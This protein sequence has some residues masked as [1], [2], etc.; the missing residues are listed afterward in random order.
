MRGGRVE[1]R[2]AEVDDL[3]VAGLGDEDVL[4]F[5]VYGG[6]V[7]RQYSLLKLLGAPSTCSLSCDLDDLPERSQQTSADNLPRCTIE[8]AWQY[9][10]ALPICLANFLALRSL[11]RPWEMM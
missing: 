9:S 8:L 10:N 6:G 4:D 2:E 11:R 7:E 1:V 3:D 5:E